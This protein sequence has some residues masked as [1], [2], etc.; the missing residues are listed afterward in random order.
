MRFTITPPPLAPVA[1]LLGAALAS[2]QLSHA[3]LLEGSTQAVR[4]DA[5]RALSRILVCRQA[6]GGESPEDES[7]GE[8]AMFGGLSLF[9]DPDPEPSPEEDLPLPCERCSHCVKSAA[10]SHPDV[11]ILEGGTGSRSFH[12]DAIRQLRQDAYI[13]PNEADRKVYVLHNAQSL[14]AEA[15]NALLKL[16]EEPPPAVCLVLTVPSA[17]M[18]LPTVL[19]R[20]TVLRLGESR[21]EAPDPEREQLLQTIAAAVAA[22]LLHPTAPYALLEATAPLESDKDLLREVLPVL[23]GAL[24]QALLSECAG[25]AALSPQVQRCLQLI[26]GV[27]QLEAAVARNANQNLLLTRLAALG[28]RA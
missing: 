6:N 7:G 4:L 15:Q 20:A 13:L 5:A 27:R 25:A 3:L 11:R 1:G 26:E 17:R 24:H 14:T 9:G 21:D 2:R 22:A 16:L 12:I 23:R 10:L 28:L 19:S 18:L 8:T